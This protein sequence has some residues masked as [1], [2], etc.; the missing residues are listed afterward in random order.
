MKNHQQAAFFGLKF[1]YTM[2]PTDCVMGKAIFLLLLS[3]CS[4][5]GAF[6][7]GTIS[8]G[9]TRNGRHAAAFTVLESSATND[10]VCTIQI[11]MSD[12][13]GGHRASANALRD[14]FDVLYP[15]KIECDIVDI[16]TDYGN[17]WPYTDYPALYKIMAKYSFLWDAFYHFGATPFGMALNAFLQEVF[18]FGSFQECLNR[19]SCST[20]RRADMVVSVHPLCQDVPL[21]AL[22]NLDSK[23][24]TREPAA[25]Q[26]PFVTVVT[27][28]G[29]VSN[30]L[31]YL[32]R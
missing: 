7:P 9:K 13:G 6:A 29:G 21:R 20:D 23:G 26:T 30:R 17:I 16:Y 4:H 24:E 11:L 1:D 15:G 25:R 28:L 32:V 22:A 12:T 5:A 31:C 18:C 14:A 19:P 10:D 27:D 2:K 8:P 3:L